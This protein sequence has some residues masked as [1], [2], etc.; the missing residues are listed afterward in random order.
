MGEKPC[1]PADALRRI[2]QIEVNGIPTGIAMLDESIAEVREQ[3]Y[4]GEHEVRNALMKRIGAMIIF[5]PGCMRHIWRLSCGNIMPNQEIG[6]S[7]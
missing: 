5:P 1:C 2:R 4:S 3:S 7:L 6:V